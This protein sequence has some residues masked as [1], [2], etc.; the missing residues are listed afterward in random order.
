[1][2]QESKKR[3]SLP[4]ACTLTPE[5]MKAQRNGLLPG[6]LAR[7]EAFEQIPGG[8]RCRFAPAPDRAMDIAAVIDTEHSCC[9]FLRFN[10]TVEPGDG[11]VWLEVTG[12]EG[13]REFLAS[14]LNEPGR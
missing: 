5:Q 7:A 9:R 1:M 3:E 14:L 4:M 6:L 2:S 11:P 12:P 8:L 10:L 13:T